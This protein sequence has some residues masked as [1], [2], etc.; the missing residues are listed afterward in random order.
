MPKDW[1]DI[2]DDEI[3]NFSGP[4]T[5]EIARY[6]RIMQKRS[7]EAVVGLRDK[8]TGLMETVYR[9]SQGLQEKSEQLFV[10]Y[11]RISKAQGRQ[12]LILIIL[13]V[14]VALS[15]A[16]Y[17]WITW[18]SVAAMRDANEIQ[19]QLLEMQKAS[20]VQQTAP[21][22]TVERD[23]RKSGARPSP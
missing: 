9:A 17:T 23:A 2:D 15:T 3:L 16:A 20:A 11:A 1:K 7:I 8:V 19:K 21:N 14:V 12:Q 6:E 22:P 18:Q 13:S 5:A 4:Q 10:L